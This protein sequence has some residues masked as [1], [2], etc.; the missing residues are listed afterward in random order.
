MLF[1]L[2]VTLGHTSFAPPL[3]CCTSDRGAPF[4]YPFLVPSP[5]PFV[6]VIWCSFP[7][8]PQAAQLSHILACKDLSLSLSPSLPSS[9]AAAS[10]PVALAFFSSSCILLLLQTICCS[11]QCYLFPISGDWGRN[12]SFIIQLLFTCRTLALISEMLFHSWNCHI[13]DET[14]R[15]PENKVRFLPF[16]EYLWSYHTTRHRSRYRYCPAQWSLTATE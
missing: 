13:P 4:S 8:P 16:Q 11:G 10:C 1:P 9:M 12:P 15:L 3:V 14:I 5:L 2:C 7:S 6:L